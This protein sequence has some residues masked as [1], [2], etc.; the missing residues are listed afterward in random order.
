MKIHILSDLHLE[1]QPY[2]LSKNDADVIILAG[3]IH[4]GEKG[5]T[6]AID[7]I[8]NI[9]ALYVLGNHETNIMVRLIPNLSI[10]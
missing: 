7:N 10:N 9:P 2:I 4:T 6:W 8:K 5:V 3:D 1:F